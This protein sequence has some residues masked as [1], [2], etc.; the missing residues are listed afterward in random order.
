MVE[1][2]HIGRSSTI[3]LFLTCFLSFVHCPLTTVCYIFIGIWG[4]TLAK[5]L[6]IV[7]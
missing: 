7:A 3:L 1:L 5:T 2:L 4:K 6:A